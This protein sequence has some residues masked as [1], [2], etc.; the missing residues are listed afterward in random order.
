VWMFWNPA[1]PSMRR[2]ST[3]LKPSHTSA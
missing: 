1:S 3:S 2:R